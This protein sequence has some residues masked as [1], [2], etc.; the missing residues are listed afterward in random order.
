MPVDLPW[1][2]PGSAATLTAYL[3]AAANQHT[4]MCSILLVAVNINGTFECEW[5]SSNS[6]CRLGL[7]S[8]SA[9]P[10]K[11]GYPLVK[12]SNFCV[13]FADAVIQHSLHLRV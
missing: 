12:N 7:W 4:R 5:N 6:T 10:T 13:D 1:N 11:V 2:A 3:V 8:P 9:L